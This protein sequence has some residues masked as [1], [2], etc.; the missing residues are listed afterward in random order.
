MKTIITK[1]Q[2]CNAI[3]STKE[4]Q[5]RKESF[6]HKKEKKTNLELSY[7]PKK[8]KKVMK[9]VQLQESR[10]LMASMPI[11]EGNSHHNLTIDSVII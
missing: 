6:I 9:N 1:R 4:I 7:V 2:I 5:N 11:Q 3:L 10:I 8:S